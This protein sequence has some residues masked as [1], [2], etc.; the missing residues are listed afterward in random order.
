MNT[1]EINKR[2]T[3]YCKSIFPTIKDFC[4]PLNDFFGISLFTYFKIYPNDQKYITLCNDF[5]VTQE[6]CSQIDNDRI[7]FQQY[8]E[9]HTTKNKLILWPKEPINLATQLVFNRGYWHG[10]NIITRYN[11]DCIEG[12]SFLSNK[13]NPEV[14]KVFERDYNTLEKFTKHFKATFMNLITQATQHKAEY[15]NGFDL[16]LPKK[17]ITSSLETK[18]FLD[19]IGYNNNLVTI[20]NRNIRITPQEMECW[21]LLS[22]GYTIK[23]IASALF[24]APKTVENHINNIRDKTE[25]RSRDSLVDLYHNSFR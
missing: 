10:L 6:Y 7:Y 11:N 18:L 19:T 13:D 12:Y 4:K 17:I 1:I 22:Q 16:S 20:D 2:Y 15:K 14:S 24:R 3:E 21:K 25:C 5:D 8:L 9:N 23:G